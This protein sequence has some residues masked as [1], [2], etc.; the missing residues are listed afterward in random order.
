MSFE[1]KEEKEIV[2]ERPVREKKDHSK[3]KKKMDI[4]DRKRKK[5][6][7]RVLAELEEEDLDEELED[8]Q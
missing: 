1:G 6:F 2:V 5:S 3:D 7:K 8:F 4:L